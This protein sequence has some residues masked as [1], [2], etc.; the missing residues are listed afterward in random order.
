MQWKITTIC[1][2]VLVPSLAVAQDTTMMRDTSQR[3]TVQSEGQLG[4][5]MAAKNHGLSSDQVKQLQEALNN[6]GCDVGTPTGDF[7]QQTL[8]GVDCIRKT[9]NV[10]S[11]NLNDVL[12]ALNLSFTASDSTLTIPSDTNTLQQ[13]TTYM[14][15]DTTTTQYDT[16]LMQHD[17]STMMQHDTSYMQHDTSLMRHDTT[18][19]RPRPH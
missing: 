13:D 1:A 19:A 10:Q 11:D 7:D 18:G 12:R 16:T 2:L 15:H 5:P 9:K 14:Q 8:Q 3:D 6:N 4:Q 17:T